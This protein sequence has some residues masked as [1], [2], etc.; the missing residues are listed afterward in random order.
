LPP[1]VLT[2]VRLELDRRNPTFDEVRVLSRN[3]QFRVSVLIYG[4]SVECRAKTYGTRA[5]I[6]FDLFSCNYDLRPEAQLKLQAEYDSYR[7]QTGFKTKMHPH[8]SRTS[9]WFDV[10]RQDAEVWFQKVIKA[11][12][13][14]CTIT[15]CEAAIEFGGYIKREADELLLGFLIESDSEVPEGSVVRMIAPAWLELVRLIQANP[16][17]MESME[18][19]RFE[20]LIAGGYKQAGFDNVILT[21]RSADH[22]VDIIAEKYG[23]GRIRIVDQVRRFSPGN[24]VSADDV[25]SLGFVALADGKRTKGVVTTTSAFAP[26]IERDRYLGPYL[27]QGRIELVSGE[28]LLDRLVMLMHGYVL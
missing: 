17:I 18:P 12:Q 27:R 14:P 10:Q 9:I 25:R 16:R 26:R 24:L 21:P 20:E 1:T 2:L 19:R 11:L 13:D 5:Q 28:R 8:F 4:S 22:G 3:G 6:D 7:N 15:L 23:L